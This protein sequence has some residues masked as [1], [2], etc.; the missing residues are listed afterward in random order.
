MTTKHELETRLAEVAA[1]LTKERLAV[2]KRDQQLAVSKESHDVERETVLGMKSK[3]DRMC[4]LISA[5][6]Y[7]TYD[8]DPRCKESESAAH[9]SDEEMENIRFLRY[10]IA[11][12][13]RFERGRA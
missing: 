5:R 11:V 7:V 6:L 3:M 12:I 8:S 10:L 2:H 13:D 9:R 1:E 4:E